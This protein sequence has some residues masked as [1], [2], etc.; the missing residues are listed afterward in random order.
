MTTARKSREFGPAVSEDEAHRVLHPG[1]GDEDPH[2]RHAGG[3]GHQPDA[4]AVELGRQPFPAEDPD[5][6][7]GGFQK[8]GQGGF[9]GQQRAEDVAHILGVAG[10]VGAELEFQGDAGHHPHGK[11][12]DKDLSPEFGHPPVVLVAGPDVDRLHDGDEDGEP[13]GQRHEEKMEKRGAGELQA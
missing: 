9:D 5:R 10:P 4:E 6:Q 11:V 1:I 7:E 13:Q 3:E 8:K 2:G 12:D